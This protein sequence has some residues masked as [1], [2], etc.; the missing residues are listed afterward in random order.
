MRHPVW[1]E[2]ASYG[3]AE[4]KLVSCRIDAV[5]MDLIPAH[6]PHSKFPICATQPNAISSSPT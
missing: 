2:E 1:F 5:N 6:T 4:R 3:R